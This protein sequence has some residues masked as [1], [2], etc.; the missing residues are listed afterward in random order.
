MGDSSQT[1]G[2]VRLLYLGRHD[3]IENGRGLTTDKFSDVELMQYIGI[4]DKHGKDIY[5]GDLLFLGLGKHHLEVR[6][7]TVGFRLFD[8]D[9]QD[10]HLLW[11]ADMKR[12]EVIGNIWETSE[13][14]A[15]REIA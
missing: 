1:Q 5:E 15:T 12:L 7:S 2:N 14:L 9:T 13:L 3:D 11:A 8:L 4:K 6:W 10:W